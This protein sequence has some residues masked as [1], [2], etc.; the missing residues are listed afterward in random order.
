MFPFTAVVN[1]ASNQ[2]FSATSFAENQDGGIG[3]RNSLNSSKHI[4][5]ALAIADNLLEIV[6]SPNFLL[7]VYVLGF[8]L[9]LQLLYLLQGRL[10]L[11]FCCLALEFRG[12]TCG[13]NLNQ[14][15]RAFI[16]LHGLVV[17]DCNVPNNPTAMVQHRNSEIAS[18]SQIS[19]GLVSRK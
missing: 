7:Q 18:S 15:D 3:W 9:F 13:K 17:N 8:Q 6:L 16:P 11:V 19:K 2:F 12:C 5:H 4:K 10:Q 14:I 1:R